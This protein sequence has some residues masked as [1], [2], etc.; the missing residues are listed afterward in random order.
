MIA[1]SE[2]VGASEDSVDEVLAAECRR[3]PPNIAKVLLIRRIA[4]G[5]Y[6]VDG[7]PVRFSWQQQ[8]DNSMQVVVSRLG[9][10]DANEKEP[11]SR[12]LQGAGAL[13]LKK[14]PAELELPS[15]PWPFDLLAKSPSD[16]R[17]VMPVA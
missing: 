3:L 11:L 5:E 9:A 4:P 1:A 6:E 7:A 16:T 13:A 10:G 2:Y 15:F 17:K 12:Y 8:A 14:A